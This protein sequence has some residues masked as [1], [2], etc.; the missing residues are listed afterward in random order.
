MKSA[1][2]IVFLWPPHNIFPMTDPNLLYD[3]DD[4]VFVSLSGAGF[5][6]RYQVLCDLRKK[7]DLELCVLPPVLQASQIRMKNKGQR[8]C[9]N[10]L[11][12][13]HTPI[14]SEH[15]CI[16]LWIHRTLDLHSDY[17][18]AIIQNGKA[19]CL[20]FWSHFA[21]RSCNTSA[22]SSSQDSVAL[23]LDGIKSAVRFQKTTSEAWLKVGRKGNYRC[24]INSQLLFHHVTLPVLF[25]R[26]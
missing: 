4:D 20:S 3:D 21:T 22:S 6:V 23:M 15:Q 16:L 1:S 26:P 13:Q 14:T 11:K 17:T 7:L 8:G 2:Q 12:H 9:S 24:Y 5:S 18:F 19:T 25:C 10:K